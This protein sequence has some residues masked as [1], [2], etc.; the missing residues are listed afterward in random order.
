M[1]LYRPQKRARVQELRHSVST[2]GKPG[3]PAD[4][5]EPFRSNIRSFLHDFARG[6]VSNA[7]ALSLPGV[8]AWRVPLQSENGVP[9][10]LYILDEKPSLSP[11]LH[12]ERCRVLGWSHHPV[13]RNRYHFIIASIELQES[14]GVGKGRKLCLSCFCV[15]PASTKMCPGCGSNA[16]RSKI[17]EARTHLLHGLIHTNGY[18]HLLRVNGREGGSQTLSGREIMDLWDRL[19]TMLR[20]RKV[21]VMD[22]SRKYN[23]EYRLLHA[24]AYGHCWYGRWGYSFGRGSY[25]IALSQYKK[26]LFT[27]SHIPLETF[28]NSIDK[29]HSRIVSLYKHLAKPSSVNSVAQL[30]CM[31]MEFLNKISRKSSIAN[32]NTGQGACSDD[33]DTGCNQTPSGAVA[34]RWPSKRLEQAQEA[35]LRVL[36]TADKATWLSR[37]ILRENARSHIGDTG[38]LDFVLKGFVDKNINHEVVRRRINETTRMLEY[39]LEAMGTGLDDQ[40]QGPHDAQHYTGVVVEQPKYDEVLEH[41]TLVYH[42][43]RELMPKDAQILMDVKQL[44]KDYMGEFSRDHYEF[45]LKRRHPDDPFRMLCYL[46]T[47]NGHQKDPPPPE[48]V[49]L[50]GNATIGDLKRA[51]EEAFQDVYLSF[52][53]LQVLAIPKL[54]GAK[55]SQRLSTVLNFRGPLCLLEVVGTGVE[56]NSSAR[57][58]AGLEQWV[59]DCPCGTT[60]D[61]GERMG[62]CIL[63]QIWL[64]TRCIGIRDSEPVPQ[65]FVC[66]LCSWQLS[67]SGGCSVDLHEDRSL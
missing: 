39:R 10:S 50:P 57:H 23:M 24:I 22:V 25:N 53:R 64:H 33:K 5:K 55:D 31:M 44:I 15:I 11:P 41:L 56:K 43:V 67:P 32:T 9:L 51:A 21:S 47:E 66:N 46:I 45:N 27:I 54:Q 49:V 12:C 28:I 62:E 8:K 59:V 26:T 19:C 30:M 48:L 3:C 14:Y 17:L 42:A 6:P 38:L 61:D 65:Q 60:D 40:R 52:E 36:R 1:V 20:A 13:C 35:L 34:C 29:K 18:G 16:M 2:L 63:C 4:Y 37:Q 58:E 7:P